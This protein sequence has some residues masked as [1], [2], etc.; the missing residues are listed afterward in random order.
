[1]SEGK[2]DSAHL[3]CNFCAYFGIEM[4]YVR[5]YHAVLRE[6]HDK[7]D[8][9]IVSNYKNE[10]LLPIPIVIITFWMIY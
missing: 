7:R 9:S 5:R 3:N 8:T 2:C 10:I 4:P 6:A 1:M